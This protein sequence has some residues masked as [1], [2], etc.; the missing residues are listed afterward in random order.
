MCQ[1]SSTPSTSKNQVTSEV[2]S[3]VI[4]QASISNVKHHHMQNQSTCLPNDESKKAV[5]KFLLAPFALPSF[6]SPCCALM[7]VVAGVASQA[8]ADTQVSTQVAESSSASASQNSAASIPAPQSRYSIV[9]WIDESHESIETELDGYAQDIDDYL[10]ENILGEDE[11]SNSG[12][13]NGNEPIN[14]DATVVDAAKQKQKEAASASLRFY[15]D[16]DWNEYDGWQTKV[17]V[18]G[19]LDLPTAEERL[20]LVFGDDSIDDEDGIAQIDSQRQLA[21]F[22][23]EGASNSDD[24]RLD[25][26]ADDA[27]DD[28][29]SLA[30]RLSKTLNETINADF[31]L[32]VRSGISD[33]YVRARAEHDKNIW[34]D[35]ELSSRQTLRYGTESK[36]HANSR[37]EVT[38][39]ISPSSY[40]SWV[41]DFTYEDEDKDRGI[42]W[43]EQLSRIHDLG[44]TKELS[45][46]VLAS[47]Q[48]GDE[49]AGIHT[50]GPWIGYEQPIFR[51]WIRIETNL[52]Y[53]KDVQEERNWHPSAFMRLALY[54]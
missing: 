45:Y 44:E 53:L 42:Q 40:N 32:G 27:V 19:K 7:F 51:D 52:S 31:D 23:G 37:F 33:V 24:S 4:N 49:D 22:R 34:R 12:N 1:P 38:Q 16:N 47:G 28:N 39:V 29:N 6:V 48:V 9:R 20:K 8:H 3:E 26:I 54:Y 5:Q 15:I 36:L 11:E 17:R 43:F 30:L 2:A 14:G 50:Y 46:G 18:R 41:S 10:S 21:S 13:S 35:Y 25:Q